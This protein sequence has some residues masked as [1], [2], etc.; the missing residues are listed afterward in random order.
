MSRFSLSEFKGKGWVITHDNRKGDD[1]KPK[2]VSAE[3]HL[4]AP[5][6]PDTIVREGAESIGLLLERL[7]AYES[8]LVST[9]YYVALE[10]AS[11]K[12]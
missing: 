11:A 12:K 10:R 6:F 2:W 7:N 1:A 5:G 8:Q 9:G 4:E 3:K